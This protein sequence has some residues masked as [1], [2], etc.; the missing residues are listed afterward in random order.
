MK[1]SPSLPKIS[2]AS[3]PKAKYQPQ[4]PF[5]I[6]NKQS[7]LQTV[8]L[9]K[10]CFQMPSKFI[11]RLARSSDKGDKDHCLVIALDKFHAFIICLADSK[12]LL[13]SK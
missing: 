1:I 12:R 7:L 9:S 10:I 8:C 13:I 6:S 2:S 3:Q 5:Q 11:K 4:Y